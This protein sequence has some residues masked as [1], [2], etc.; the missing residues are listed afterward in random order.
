MRLG[1]RRSEITS[2][3]M[4]F[5]LYGGQKTILERHRHRYEVN[6][7]Y[8][9]DLEK[10]GMVFTGVDNDRM[11][12]AEIPTLRFFVACQ[13]HPE[14]TSRPRDPNPLFLGFVLAAAKLLDKRLKEDGGVLCVGSGWGRP[15]VVRQ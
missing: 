2:D 12:I 3:S 13:F 1:L 6:P 7:K 4:A 10:A 11:E 14:F 8:V 5:K 9:A 15:V